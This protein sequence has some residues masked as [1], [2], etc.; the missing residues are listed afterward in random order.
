MTATRLSFFLS[1]PA[2]LAAGGYESLTAADAV[3]ASDG[4]VPTLAVTAVSLVVAYLSIRL[5]AAPGRPAPD[6]GLR[7]LPGRAG[8]RADAGAEHRADHGNLI[9]H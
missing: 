7:R 2:L 3:S 1:I 5:A 9:A 6:H 8:S 4:W